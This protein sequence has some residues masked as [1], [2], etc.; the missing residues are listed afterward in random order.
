MET[1]NKKYKVSMVLVEVMVMELEDSIIYV[2]L[3]VERMKLLRYLMRSYLKLVILLVKVWERP[4][5][6]L[7]VKNA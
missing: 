4:M 5:S 3:R 6:L 7:L 2:Y 1:L